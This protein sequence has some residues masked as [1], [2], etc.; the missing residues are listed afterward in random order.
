[1]PPALASTVEFEVLTAT[2]TCVYTSP[3]KDLAKDRA[4]QLSA[5]S[6]CKLT[7]EEVTRTISR[8]KVSTVLVKPK[9]GR[10]VAA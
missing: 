8:K 3:D 2:G 4:R 1:M 6:G 10:A 9:G 7:V 5:A